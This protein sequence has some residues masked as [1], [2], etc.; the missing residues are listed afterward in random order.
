VFSLTG[1]SPRADSAQ[2]PQP[3]DNFA[4]VDMRAVGVRLA[5]PGYVQFAI[6]T[7]GRRAHPNYPAEF[8]VYIDVDRDGVPDFVVYNSELGGFGVSGSNVVNVRNLATGA[9]AIYFYTDA[10]LNSASAIFTRTHCRTGNRRHYDLR[11]FRV[12]F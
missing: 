1:I 7:F 9:S 2:L 11:L 12:C 4:F 6:N 5:A 8:D 3:G 10:D